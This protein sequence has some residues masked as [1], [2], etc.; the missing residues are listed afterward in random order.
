MVDARAA[1]CHIICSSLGGTK[2][3][4]GLKATVVKEDEWDF[5]PFEC[6]V[7]VGLN[8][9]VEAINAYDKNISIDFVANEYL[10]FFKEIRK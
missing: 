1:G 7:P 2:E 6:N 5:I 10:N 8:F 3:V 9:N 4:A